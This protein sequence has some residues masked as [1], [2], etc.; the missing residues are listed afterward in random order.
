MKTKFLSS[1]I[2]LPLFLLI[3]TPALALGRPDFAN[4]P[5]LSPTG[6]QNGKIRACQAKENAI[7][8]RISHLTAL[9]TTMES[10]FDSIATRVKDHYTNKVVPSGKTVA[11][12][13]DLVADIQTKKDAVDTALKT[14]QAD[15]DSFSCTSTNPKD[16]LTQFRTD[17]KNVKKALKEYRTSIKNLIVAVRSVTGEENKATETPTP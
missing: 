14:A 12:Y 10:K 5:D 7:K 8:N 2:L 3:V 11:N 17:M 9:V 1:A 13:D 15:V 6:A 4:K 16:Q